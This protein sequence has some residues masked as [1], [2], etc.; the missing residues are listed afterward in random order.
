MSRL[1]EWVA[2]GLDPVNLAVKLGMKC[3]PWQKDALRSTAPRLHLNIHRQG[4]KSTTT[5][6]AAVH[7]ALYRPGSLT[8]IV[9]PTQRQSSE[10]FRKALVFYRLLGRPV[11]AETENALSLTLEN[12]SRVIS[13]PGSEAGIRT[14]SADLL[15]IDEAA[16]VGDEVFSAISPMV[17][18]TGGRII[19]MSTPA[20]R[21]GW[22]Y[23]ASLSNRWEHLVAKASECPRIHK[24]F[25]E[26]ELA[27]LGQTV[28]SQ[29]YECQFA[30]AAGAA[31]DGADIDAL[32]SGVAPPRS[33]PPL[34]PAVPEFGPT[35][36]ETARAIQRHARMVQGRREVGKRARL[37]AQRRCEHRWRDTTCV[38]CGAPKEDPPC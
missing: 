2:G 7:E 8:L 4:G 15:I 32:F 23:S 27:S 30:D 33:E 25:L 20:G 22:W 17:A 36:L 12:G 9:S 1:G 31:F 37:R 13:V 10:L 34:A 38:W 24:D 26:D 5:A 21:R 18:V 19:A 3:D 16:R 29:E 28:F 35:Q 11:E 14:Y 6:V